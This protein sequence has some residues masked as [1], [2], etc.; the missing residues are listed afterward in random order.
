M[1]D[2]DDDNLNDDAEAMVATMRIVE[3]IPY[4]STTPTKI[5]VMVVVVYLPVSI[6][7]QAVT[8]SLWK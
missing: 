7:I 6:Y 4:V 1:S 5:E 2:D 3:E 8:I